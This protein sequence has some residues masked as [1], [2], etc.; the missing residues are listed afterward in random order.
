MTKLSNLI[1]ESIKDRLKKVT[2]KPKRRMI[3]RELIAS[4]DDT[5][6]AKC[7]EIRWQEHQDRMTQKCVYVLF[8]CGQPVRRLTK[9]Q[10][11]DYKAIGARVEEVTPN[12]AKKYNL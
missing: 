1:G 3:T 10:A 12:E 8:I 2:S 9:D 11:L 4:S 7:R 6:E 5:I